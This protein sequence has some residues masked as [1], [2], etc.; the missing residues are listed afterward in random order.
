MFGLFKNKKKQRIQEYLN[1][2]A[3]LLD[4][5]TS[6]EFNGNNIP[7]SLNI[8]LSSLESQLDKLDKEKPIIAYCKMGGRST[9]A[10]AKLKSKGFKVIDA[11]GI[12]SV[13]K[14]IKKN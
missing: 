8:P 6:S 4:V 10:T 1:Q 13:K 7:G 2:D 9:M 11:G 5:R 3:L 12:G 14:Q